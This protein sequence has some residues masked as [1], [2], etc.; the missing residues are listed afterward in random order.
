VIFDDMH[1]GAT[2]YYDPRKFFADPRL[3]H[4]LGWL[5]ALWFAYV[6]GARPLLAARSG[7]GRLDDTAML[8]VTGGFLAHV[9]RPADAA[10]RLFELFFNDLRRRRGL[11]ETG[12]PMWDW[13]AQQA[14]V[15]ATGLAQLRQW[16][17]RAARGRRVDL[18]R[19]HNSLLELTGRLS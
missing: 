13:L 18:V 19:L 12:A 2:D 9:L 7:R 15:D 3:H 4:T 16:H 10:L 11:Q 8:R 6:L 14:R 17:E 1:Q 5:V